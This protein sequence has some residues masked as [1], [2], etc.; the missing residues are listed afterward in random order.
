MRNYSFQIDPDARL[1]RRRVRLNRSKPISVPAK[2]RASSAPNAASILM[3][4]RVRHHVES[5]KTHLSAMLSVYRG[6]DIACTELADGRWIASFS[7]ADGGLLRTG[8]V[9]QSVIITRPYVSEV[10]AMA[11]AQLRID[12][13]AEAVQELHIKYKIAQ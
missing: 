7:R 8:G 13:L 6:F 5:S 9:N 1:N 11:E 12:A 3:E 2:P 10:L 4:R